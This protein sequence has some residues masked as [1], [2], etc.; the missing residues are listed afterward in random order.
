MKGSNEMRIYEEKKLLD[1]EF[2]GGAKERVKY[3]TDAEMEVLE[4]CLLDLHPD[5]IEAVVLN[6]I[7]WHDSDF[8]AQLVGYNDFEEIIN[9]REMW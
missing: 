6:N 5:G 7:F 9:D 4:E 8:L 2:W 3:F 1:F